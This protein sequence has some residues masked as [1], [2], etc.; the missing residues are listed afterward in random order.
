M[1]QDGLITQ[2][3]AS[4]GIGGMAGPLSTWFLSLQY[5][6]QACSHGGRGVPH[7]RAEAASPLAL[8]V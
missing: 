8:E 4:A 7:A 6:A 2:Q 3:G 5:L 1:V